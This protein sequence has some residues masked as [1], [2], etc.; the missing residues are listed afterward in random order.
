M[1]SLLPLLLL[2]AAPA[3]ARPAICLV[4]IDSRT[5]IDGP[6]TF[7]PLDDSGSFE[8]L[9]PSGDWFVYVTVVEPGLADGHWNGEPGATHAHAPLG[10]LARNDACWSNER[11]T[12]CAW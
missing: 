2:A 6:C 11:A 3:V 1:R 9:S 12:V 5:V 4:E 8:V 10:R 7:E